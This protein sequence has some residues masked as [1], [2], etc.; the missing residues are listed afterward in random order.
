MSSTI[1]TNM[2]W[3][4]TPDYDLTKSTS[5]A[6]DPETGIVKCR[7][8][9]VARTDRLEINFCGNL[10]EAQAEKI[11]S[12]ANQTKGITLVGSVPSEKTYI[13]NVVRNTISGYDKAVSASDGSS[14][15]V[16]YA[17]D[18]ENRLNYRNNYLS[19]MT[20]TAKGISSSLG[21]TCSL[22]NLK[23]DIASYFSTA[24]SRDGDRFAITHAYENALK[25]IRQNIAEGKENPAAD[26][27]TTL[28]I[29]GTTWN[30]AELINT[31]EK[32]NKSFEY[33]DSKVNLDYSDYAKIGVS[34]A[35][36]KSW[37]KANLSRDK[38]DEIKKSLDARVNT[39]ILREKE[40]LD[41]FRHIW[42]KPGIVMPEEKA[43]YYETAVLSASNKEARESIMKL[44]EETDYGFSSAVSDTVNKYRNIMSPIYLAFGATNKALPEYLDS[45]VNDIFKYISGLFGG[46]TAQG[47]NISV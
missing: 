5:G 19:Y 46:E 31:V 7:E 11:R 36:V 21:E 10:P 13:A 6:P 26:L 24:S 27:K 23:S 42:D 35:D 25:E 18:K 29:N 39:L 9:T 30:F 2:N 8:G 1:Y 43:K 20:E 28:T 3:K 47:L 17:Y 38:Q 32:L 37:A 16:R 33:F 4:A 40:G 34:K 45:A 41:V 22:Y 12:Y 44:F 15:T 14:F